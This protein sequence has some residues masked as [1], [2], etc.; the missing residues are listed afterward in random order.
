MTVTHPKWLAKNFTAP[1]WIMGVIVIV[2]ILIIVNTIWA[3]R[4]IQ[5]RHGGGINKFA[6]FSGAGL[7]T[8]AVV[9]AV[10][11]WRIRRKK[12]NRARARAHLLLMLVS[13]VVL[14]VLYISFGRIARF[15]L[16]SAR[17]VELIRMFGRLQFFIFWVC[18]ITGTALFLSIAIKAFSPPQEKLEDLVDAIGDH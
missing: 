12:Y 6:L 3:M 18:F 15:Y 7:I 8:I 13:M 14:P 4:Q 17:F 5:L 9:E 11:Y 2:R 1:V 10:V 16:T